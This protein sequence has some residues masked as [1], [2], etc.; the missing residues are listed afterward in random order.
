MTAEQQMSS[1]A[2]AQCG[3]LINPPT[4]EG[5]SK[6]IQDRQWIPDE[7]GYAYCSE[8]H[9]TLGPADVDPRLWLDI[10][11]A[12]KLLDLLYHVSVPDAQRPIWSWFANTFARFVGRE[13]HGDSFTPKPGDQK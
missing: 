1:F 9:R 5:L 10:A 11:S 2:C 13:S 8:E 6:Q 4:L 7:N 3:C 12:E